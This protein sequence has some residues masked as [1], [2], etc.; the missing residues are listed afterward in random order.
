MASNTSL[1]GKDRPCVKFQSSDG[2]QLRVDEDVI[3]MCVGMGVGVGGC[4]VAREA[5][6][7][8]LYL[9]SAC[10]EACALY[11]HTYYEHV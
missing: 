9:Q 5:V 11:L 1:P 8:F 10:G 7:W 3:G 6:T 4:G 2:Y